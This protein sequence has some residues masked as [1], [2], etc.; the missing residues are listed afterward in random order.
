MKT[1]VLLLL[2]GT[3]N[4]DVWVN[5]DHIVRMFMH[6]GR[7]TLTMTD[8][9]PLWFSGKSRKQVVELIRTGT[10]VKFIEN[11]RKELHVFVRPEGRTVEQP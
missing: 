7:C 11:T 5:P 10:R 2:L 1:L 9:T 8:G 3:H 4:G 6:D